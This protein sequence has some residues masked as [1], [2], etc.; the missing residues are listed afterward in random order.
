MILVSES[1]SLS[2]EGTSTIVRG[3]SLVSNGGDATMSASSSVGGT[4]GELILDSGSGSTIWV[5][6]SLVGSRGG[7]DMGGCV[8]ISLGISSSTHSGSVVISSVN[9]GSTCLYALRHNYSP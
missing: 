7:S 1:S 8:S 5:S 2:N 4:G 6:M 3:E 9:T